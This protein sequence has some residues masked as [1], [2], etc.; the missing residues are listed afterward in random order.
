MLF[1][2][3]ALLVDPEPHAA[4]LNMAWDEVWLKEGVVQQ[5]G[6]PL[7]RVYRWAVPAVSIGYFEPWAPVAAAHPRRELV[8][9][10]TGGGV[11]LH[12]EDWTYSL[13]VPRSHPFSQS[14]P[15]DSYCAVHRSLASALG[16]LSVGGAEVEVSPVADTKVSA[17]CFENV[18]RDDLTLGGR[19]VG[20]AA[21]RRSR[22]GL[23]HQ[24]SVLGVELPAGFAEQW[25]A[26]LAKKV[27]AAPAH[28]ALREQM[29]L[30]TAA[31]KYATRAWREK[32]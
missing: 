14:R 13:V 23:L 28:D 20:G 17:A 30:A 4:P 5:A 10:W 18:V 9:R 19:K 11:V 15:G 12:G 21:Q 25:A 24:G 29:A 32:F 26:R 3:L 31:E 16:A 8:R 27:V 22:H 7:L 1:E 2:T 6:V